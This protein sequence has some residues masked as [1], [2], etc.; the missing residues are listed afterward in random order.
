MQL[1][2]SE[3]ELL[4]ARLTSRVFDL[5]DDQFYGRDGDHDVVDVHGVHAEPVV[6][7]D[8]VCEL[9]GGLDVLFV[10]GLDLFLILVQ[11]V[12]QISECALL[13]H[14]HDSSRQPHIV[15][16]VNEYLQ[17]QQVH[18]LLVREYQMPL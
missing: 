13:R 3:E 4:F 5:F 16:R 15:I 2:S 10:G 8:D 12:L 17:I 1:P 11:Q 14:L 6:G 7:D 18:H 9:L